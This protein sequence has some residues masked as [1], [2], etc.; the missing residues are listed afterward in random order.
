MTSPFDK[1]LVKFTE[2]FQGEKP[3]ISSVM[4]NVFSMRVIGNKTHGDLAEIALTEYINEYV[5]GY[6][7]K[8]TGKEK[9]R[10]KEY[11]EDISVTEESTKKTIP[12]SLKAYGSGPLQLSTNKDGSMFKR[13][14]KFVRKGE[15]TDASKIKSILEHPS[16]ANIKRINILP[17]IYKERKEKDGKLKGGSFKMIIFDIAKA[18][19]SARKIT[20]V[21]PGKRGRK[22]PVYR[23][24][25]DS[26][27]YIFEIRYG[28]TM[29]NALQRGMWTHTKNAS[30]YFRIILSGSY[31][32]NE[33]LI[34]LMS[35]ILNCSKEKHEKLL[36]H[37]SGKLP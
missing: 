8:H 14:E 16:F 2:S 28:Y 21:G 30:S 20:Y 36:K 24:F 7:A 26:D 29:A 35:K 19:E 27:E 11:E 4:A 31:E 1:F 18:Y 3:I 23:F 33:P 34:N 15:I 10:A 37:F 25:T 13:L 17:L 22:H 5:D 12:I 9:F 32:I 6:T